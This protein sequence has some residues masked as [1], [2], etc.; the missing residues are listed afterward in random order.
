MIYG[1]ELLQPNNLEIEDCSLGV[2][3]ENKSRDF[4]ARVDELVFRLPEHNFPSA[5]S[6]GTVEIAKVKDLIPDQVINYF[7]KGY[8]GISRIT[9]FAR[10]RAEREVSVAISSECRRLTFLIDQQSYT[11]ELIFEEINDL[12]EWIKMENS[13]PLSW[14]EFETGFYIIDKISGVISQSD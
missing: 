2:S 9:V 6:V 7:N 1:K 3:D 8:N 12:G 11:P 10:S 5:T 14:Q 4:T 13:Y